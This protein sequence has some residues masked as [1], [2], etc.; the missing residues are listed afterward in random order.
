MNLPRSI[1]YALESQN[2]DKGKSDYTVTELISPAFQNA[3][4]Q[5]HSAYI[6]EDASDRIWALLGS[7]VHYII[8][9]AHKNEE[10]SFAEKR[11][12]M[13]FMDK[14][15]SG[16]FD[17]FQDGILTDFKVTSAWAI[18]DGPKDDWIAQ[19]NLL[20]LLLNFQRGI[21]VEKLQIVAILRD[22][23]DTTRKK[24]PDWYP[25][26]PIKVLDIEMWDRKTQKAYL[27]D[28]IEKHEDVRF[29]LTGKGAD[30]WKDVWEG[31][32]C[33]PEERWRKPHTWAV[34]RH[35]QKRALK[36]YKEHEY[37]NAEQQASDFCDHKNEEGQ[38]GE[39][40][41]YV[42]YRPGEDTRC[43]SYCPVSNHCPY[44]QHSYIGV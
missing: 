31:L 40:E 25:R 20:D 15:I 1:V 10:N 27:Q 19:L 24:N 6:K 35:G 39:E 14:T 17:L 36:L 37:M 33:T 41:Y 26:K 28:R 22:W 16:Q 38:K 32:V 12:Y 13:P 8:E 29:Y 2:Y 9:Q 23:S 34:M 44:Y 5:A 42:Q 7:S 11:I 21:R 30:R 43:E 3:L 18:K 4:K